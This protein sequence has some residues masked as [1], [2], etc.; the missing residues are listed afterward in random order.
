MFNVIFGFNHR[1]CYYHPFLFVVLTL[2]E[3]PWSF[4]AIGVGFNETE[5][6]PMVADRKGRPGALEPEVEEEQTFLL[7]HQ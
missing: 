2:D 4:V 5:P 7:C 1:T 6:T 3:S